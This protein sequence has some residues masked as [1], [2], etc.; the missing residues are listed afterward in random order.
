MVQRSIYG[1][2]SDFSSADWGAIQYTVYEAEL[3]KQI[4]GL[5]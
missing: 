4:R 2:T 3:V 1:F 5:P